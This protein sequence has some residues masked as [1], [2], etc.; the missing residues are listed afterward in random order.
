MK[1][2]ISGLAIFA[3]GFPILVRLLTIP[4]VLNLV[5]IE[6]GNYLG[7]GLMSLE[8]LMFAL[9]IISM[10]IALVI[11]LFNHDENKIPNINFLGYYFLLTIL[12]I[13]ISITIPI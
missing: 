1:R 8:F 6:Q 11:N 4:S 5:G 12:F 2:I 7:Y 13:L 10:S 3:F 9:P